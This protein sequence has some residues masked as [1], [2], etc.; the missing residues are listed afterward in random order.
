MH[1][2]VSEWLQRRGWNQQQ[3]CHHSV[4]LFAGRWRHHTGQPAC[5]DHPLASTAYASGICPTS[6]LADTGVTFEAGLQTG[7][8]LSAYML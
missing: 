3:R 1:Q 5:V 2:L 6:S 4:V 8:F 7:P